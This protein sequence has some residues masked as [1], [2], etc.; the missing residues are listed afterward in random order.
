MKK[1]FII[2]LLTFLV[3]CTNQDEEIKDNTNSPVENENIEETANEE[4]E[5]NEENG[6]IE[7]SKNI[8]ENNLTEEDNMDNDLPLANTILFS[9]DELKKHSSND[10][11]Y[12][13]IDWKVYDIT[14]FFWEHP[15]W[16][17]NLEKLCWIDWS[18]FFN[19]QHWK[20]EKA[21]AT[22]ETF[23]IWDFVK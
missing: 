17:K 7:E 15:W 21:K 4:N 22:K 11:C 10:D 14:S 12:T 18:E 20:S 8:E 9:F 23:Y 13:I 5:E 6:N 19:S 2:L 1:I 3:S 16:D